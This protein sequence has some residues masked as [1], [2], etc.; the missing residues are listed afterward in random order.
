MT[1]KIIDGWVAYPVRVEKPHLVRAIQ[2]IQN[3]KDRTSHCVLAHAMKDQYDGFLECCDVCV[4]VAQRHRRVHLRMEGAVNLVRHFDQ[5]KYAMV[6][7]MLPM[8]VW[9]Y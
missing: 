1:T 5:G 9:M 3:K 8:T 4:V 6:E 2:D 7:R